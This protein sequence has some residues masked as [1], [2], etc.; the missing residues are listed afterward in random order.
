VT[1][2]YEKLSLS[3]SWVF[4]SLLASLWLPVAHGATSDIAPTAAVTELERTQMAQV[5]AFLKDGGDPNDRSEEAYHR[6]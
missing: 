2:G 1:Y 5:H 6:L 3:I 4:V